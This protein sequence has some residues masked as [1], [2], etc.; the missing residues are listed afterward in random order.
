MP[1]ALRKRW[2]LRLGDKAEVLPL[3]AEE[4]PRIDLFVYDVPHD[5]DRTRAE[6]ARLDPVVPAGAVAIVDH[7]PGGGL[8]EALRIWGRS[9]GS[10][11]VRRRELGLYGVRTRRSR[12]R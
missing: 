7:G 8:C 1:F 3:L 2:D 9:R 4:L 6:L 11:P 12:P 10:E 5:D